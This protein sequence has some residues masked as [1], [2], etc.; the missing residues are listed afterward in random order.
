MLYRTNGALDTEGVL[1]RH[2]VLGSPDRNELAKDDRSELGVP[3]ELTLIA[4]IAIQL[5]TELANCGRTT[6]GND[7]GICESDRPSNTR[8]YRTL[9][10]LLETELANCERTTDGND[11]DADGA[12]DTEGILLRDVLGSPDRNELAKDDG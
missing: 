5:G 4:V 3:L 9:G 1:L 10:M 8:R 6:D 11:C 2:V 12:I 7:D